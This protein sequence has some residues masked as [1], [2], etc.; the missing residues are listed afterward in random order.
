[1][2]NQEVNQKVIVIEAVVKVVMVVFGGGGDDG[3]DSCGGDGGDGDY[4]RKGGSRW[5]LKGKQYEEAYRDYVK[6]L[7][8]KV[9][10]MDGTTKLQK[11]LLT[12]KQLLTV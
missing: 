6:S 9:F 10:R 8:E 11:N 2:P 12:L 5:I 7:M 3:R 4:G 1:M